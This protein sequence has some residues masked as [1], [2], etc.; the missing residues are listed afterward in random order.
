MPRREQYVPPKVPKGMTAEEFHAARSVGT[1]EA[2]RVLG[3]HPDTVRKLVADGKLAG[4][5]VG[6]DVRVRVAELL[7]YVGVVTGAREDR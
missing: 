7:R 1:T 2:G 6:T 4:Y 5:R 3:C